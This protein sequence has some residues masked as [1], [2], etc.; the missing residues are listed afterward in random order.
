MMPFFNE[1]FGNPHSNNHE[2]GRNANEAVQVARQEIS[3][4]INILTLTIF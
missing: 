3:N 1:N 4:L 2:Y